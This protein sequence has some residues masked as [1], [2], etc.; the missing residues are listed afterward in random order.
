MNLVEKAKSQVSEFAGE[1]RDEASRLTTEARRQVDELAD[2]RKA[3]TAAKLGNVAEALRDAARRLEQRNREGLMSYADHWADRVDEASAYL[4]GREI[5]ELMT[6][7]E[8]FARRRPGLVLGGSLAAGILAARFLKSSGERGRRERLL[9]RE[10]ELT[11]SGRLGKLVGDRPLAA[12][13][14]TLALGLLAGLA[15]PATHRE[16]EWM[17]ERRDEVLAE[18]KQAGR[19]TLEKG[20]ELA[21][22]AVDHVRQEVEGRAA[23]ESEVLVEIVEIE[24]SAPCSAPGAPSVS[25]GP[26]GVS[27]EAAHWRGSGTG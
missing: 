14:A 15:L 23:V 24:V 5:S 25:S 8:R 21:R 26:G 11:S 10:P 12:G 16:D 1:V 6:D 9:R 18:V 2:Q 17:G 3:Q 4:R 13:A 22:D 27:P 19:D 20:R 7:L